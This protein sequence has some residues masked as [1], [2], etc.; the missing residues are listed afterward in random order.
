MTSLYKE[1]TEVRVATAIF[2]PEGYSQDGFDMHLMDETMFILS[3]E[4]EKMVSWSGPDH[5]DSYIVLSYDG[6]EEANLN[7]ASDSQR[8]HLSAIKLY[9]NC[10]ARKAQVEAYAAPYDELDQRGCDIENGKHTPAEGEYKEISDEMERIQD[11]ID[12]RSPYEF[13]DKRD[14]SEVLALGTDV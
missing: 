13:G 3:E 10:A 2:P 8:M 12:A 14:L 6:L 11:L 5:C 1:I 7:A 9:Q 4:E